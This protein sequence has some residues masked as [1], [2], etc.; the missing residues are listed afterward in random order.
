MTVL[1]DGYGTFSDSGLVGESDYAT[2]ARTSDGHTV[3][4]YV[5]TFRT[6]TVNMTSVSG[7]KVTAWW[8]NP[9][10]GSA[11]KFGTYITSGSQDFTPPDAN[12]WVLV[13]DDAAIPFTPPAAIAAAVPGAITP[14]FPF[15]QRGGWFRSKRFTWRA[16]TNAV[17]YELYVTH[18]GS[19]FSDKGFTLGDSMVDSATGNFAVDV[20]GHTAGSYQWYVRGGS[21]CGL[22]PWSGPMNFSLAFRERRPC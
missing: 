13:L 14:G 12:D 5:P 8:Y 11:T 9:R 21:P 15:G 10:D 6:L 22:G 4:I 17:Q 19:L 2:A 3:M 1:T 20:S 7:T 16:D 18:N